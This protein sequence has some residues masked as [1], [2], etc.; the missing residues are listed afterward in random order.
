MSEHIN[1]EM[2]TWARKRNRLSVED[3]AALMKKEPAEIRKWEAGTEMPS[4]ANLE[5][6]SYRHLKVPLALFFFPEPPSIEDPVSKF[7]RLPE[8]EFRRISTDTMQ[9]MRVAQGY[10][11]SLI[12]FANDGTQQRK[13]FRE[14]NRKSMT[15]REMA[16]KTRE[17]LGITIKKQM[18]FRSPEEAFKHWRHS[19]EEAGIFTFKGSLEDKFISGFCLLHEE[20]PIIFINNSNSFTRQIFTLVHELGHIIFEIHGV[21]DVD[22][23]YLDHM[24]Q[25]DRSLEIKCNQYAAEVLVPTDSFE[26][27]ILLFRDKGPDAIP[28]IAEKY[29][30]SKEVILRRLLDQKL[31]TADYYSKKAEE[32]NQD[33]LRSKATTGGGNYELPSVFRLP[34]GGFHATRFSS[35]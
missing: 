18:A 28:K 9:M 31:V 29:S 15:V 4:Y 12:E 33:F 21:T 17:H 34:S 14:L 25:K 10:Q 20:F 5:A 24:G 23:K 26:N 19:L 13:L 27:D 3:L 7:R 1:R 8:Y 35:C 2:I 22:E 16:S 6:L 30:V 11:E 32:W